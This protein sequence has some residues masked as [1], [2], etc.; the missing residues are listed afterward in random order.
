MPGAWTP[1]T[2]GTG[3]LS[4]WGLEGVGEGQA[5]EQLAADVPLSLGQV[6]W[7]GGVPASPARE[8]VREGTSQLGLA[9]GC[10]VGPDTPAHWSPFCFAAA[11][12][13]P[14]KR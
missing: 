11:G 8:S 6:P 14:P 4:P 2:L 13:P 7:T 5:P 3:H 1:V 10:R 9:R 12:A